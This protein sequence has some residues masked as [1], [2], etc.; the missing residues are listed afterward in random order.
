VGRWPANI[1]HDGSEEVLQ[2]FPEA[3]GQMAASRADGAPMNNKIYGAMK[4]G[5]ESM[6]PREDTTKS[7]SRFF[8]C[9]K[10]SKADREEGLKGFAE[11]QYSHDGRQ[12]PIDNAYQRNSNSNS[13]HHPTVKPTALMRYLCRLVTS[14][15]GTVLDPFM[16]SGSTGKGAVLEGFQFI[17]IELDPEYCRIAEA[18]IAHVEANELGDLI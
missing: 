12:T 11:K 2:A 17:G 8:Y 14:P 15:G 9:A 16:G 7:A 13:N 4:F 18:R 1:I 3:P 10:T 5:T 6:I